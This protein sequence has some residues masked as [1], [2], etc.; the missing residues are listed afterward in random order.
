MNQKKT[1]ITEDG[2][3]KLEEEL[4]HLKTVRRREVAAAIQAAKE[5]GDLSENAEY[6]DAKEEQGLVEQHILELEATLKNIEVIHKSNSTDVEVGNTVTVD[7]AG[8]E[9]TFTIVGPNEASPS[10]GRISHESPLGRALLGRKVGDN[11]SVRTPAGSK[12]V[13]VLKVG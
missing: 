2:L 12:Q 5:Q 13:R 7:M 1:L 11:L 3:R 9:T 4:Q 10:E 8:A 6:V